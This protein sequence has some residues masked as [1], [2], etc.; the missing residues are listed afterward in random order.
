MKCPNCGQTLKPEATFCPE[1]GTK[2]EQKTCPHCGAAMRDAAVFCPMCG[3]PAAEQDTMQEVRDTQPFPAQ[4]EPPAGKGNGI[5]I[6][7]ICCVAAVL[8]VGIV[9]ATFLK[10]SSQ[11]KEAALAQQDTPSVGQTEIPQTST[12]TE[13]VETGE[14]KV[15]TPVTTSETETNV[16][17][18][19]HA[20]L[21][22]EYQ[23]RIDGLW[24]EMNAIDQ[25]ARNQ[26][27]LSQ[28]SYDNY[29]HWDS[30]LNEIYQ[31]I[32]SELSS[33]AFEVLKDSETAWIAQR[34][35]TADR[36]AAD[37]VGGTGYTAVYYG[38]LSSSTGKRC[39]WLVDQYL[40]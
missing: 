13:T 26:A 37:W 24:T 40:N 11:N 27:D 14:P 36:Q 2:A 28:L 18:D 17:N 29:Q 30:L 32:K 19:R 22:E 25:K 39:Q 6:A 9:S 1:C 16:S 21:R 4:P 38:S 3:Q 10:V 35:A 34:D 15:E 33:S 31:D 7:L 20:V 5:R 12:D 8:I 23:A